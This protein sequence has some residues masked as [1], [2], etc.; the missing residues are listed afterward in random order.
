MVYVMSSEN[1]TSPN[2]WA[3][4]RAASSDVDARCTHMQVV[5]A[6][7]ESLETRPQPGQVDPR[8]S[9]RRDG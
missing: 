2:L 5:G 6:D 3:E 1:A 4:I 7:V 9:C 8:C